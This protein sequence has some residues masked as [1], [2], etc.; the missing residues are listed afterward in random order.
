MKKLAFWLVACCCI[1]SSACNT[2]LTNIPGIYRLDIE[3]GNIIDQSMIDQLRPNMT[4][5]QVIFIMGSPMLS[6]TFHEK[7][8]DY[9]Y[10]KEPNGEDRVQKRIS[11]FF[12]GDNLIGIQGDFR[13]NAVPVIAETKEN[14]LELPKR[15]IEKSMWEKVAGLFGIEINDAPESDSPTI[16]N[17]SGKSGGHKQH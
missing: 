11:L 4:K 10:A 1:T 9:L 13:P 16:K 8:W 17:S 5:R 14:T 3:Q 6:D 15:D 12:N 2:I 7:R